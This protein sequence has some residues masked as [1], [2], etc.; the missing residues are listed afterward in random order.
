VLNACLPP[1]LLLL[2][3]LIYLLPL[4]VTRCCQ[5]WL[6]SWLSCLQRTWLTAAW[7]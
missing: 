3:L 2:L 7:R 5:G 6:L 4:V 1:P